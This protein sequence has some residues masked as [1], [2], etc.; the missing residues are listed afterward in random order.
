MNNV[1]TIKGLEY[2]DYSDL[3]DLSHT[4]ENCSSLLNLDITH[5]DISNVKTMNS[6]FKNCTSI[7][8]IYVGSGFDASSV[9]EGDDMFYGDVNIIGEEGTQYKESS[10]DKDFARVDGKDGVP[11]Y[12]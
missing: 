4:F 7:N 2:I 5:M 6:M 3:Y 10:T 1:T 8:K 11:G 12:L 9:S